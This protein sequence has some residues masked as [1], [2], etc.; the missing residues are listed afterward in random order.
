M[1]Q[2]NTMVEPSGRGTEDFGF[3]YNN[4]ARGGPR[5]LE[6]APPGLIAAQ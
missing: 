4:K 3:T 2:E 5:S 6:S 1:Y